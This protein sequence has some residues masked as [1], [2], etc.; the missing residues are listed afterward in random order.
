MRFYLLSSRF[1]PS[2]FCDTSQSCFGVPRFAN[3]FTP[4]M[5]FFSFKNVQHVTSN[6]PITVQRLNIHI[7]KGKVVVISNHCCIYT[8]LEGHD[9]I[10]THN[11]CCSKSKSVETPK[12][13]K[14]G[15]FFSTSPL[16][17]LAHLQDTPSAK[18]VAEPHAG[19]DGWTFLSHLSQMMKISFGIFH[20][21]DGFSVATQWILWSSEKYVYICLISTYL[22][23]FNIFKNILLLLHAFLFP[24]IHCIFTCLHTYIY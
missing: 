10:F 9:P 24:C 3:Q 5:R 20:I 19:V 13:Q 14:Q 4:P 12:P 6:F 1:S 16:L 2:L 18:T 7:C 21:W 8:T 11:F 17:L 23:T 15:V 22:Y